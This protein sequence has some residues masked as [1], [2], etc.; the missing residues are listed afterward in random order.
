MNNATVS[1]TEVSFAASLYEAFRRLRQRCCSFAIAG[2]SDQEVQAI[3]ASRMDERHAGH[4]QTSAARSTAEIAGKAEYQSPNSI[5]TTID[6]A[7]AD[8]SCSLSGRISRVPF[9]PGVPLP[10]PLQPSPTPRM[11]RRIRAAHV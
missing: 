3:G 5:C 2:L 1:D 7:T 9:N 4:F 8:D 11:L 6:P 10:N